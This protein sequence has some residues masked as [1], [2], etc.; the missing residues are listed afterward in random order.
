MEK[1]VRIFHSFE[2]AD[3]AG[4]GDNLRMTPQERIARVLE[5]RRLFYPDADPQGF[6][7]VYRIIELERS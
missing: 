1:T 4:V 6:S 7:R 2:E 5:L 3:A